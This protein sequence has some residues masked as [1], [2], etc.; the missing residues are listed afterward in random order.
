MITNGIY[1]F[2]F[3]SDQKAAEVERFNLT[4]K[5]GYG[6]FERKTDKEVGRCLTRYFKILQW[7]LSL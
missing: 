6:L 2:A 5:P 4:L 7:E 3:E 1:Y